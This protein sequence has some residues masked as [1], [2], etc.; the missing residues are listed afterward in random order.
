MELLVVIWL[1]TSAWVLFDAYA[2][3]ARRGLLPGLVDM[4]PAGW[5]LACLLLWVIAFPLYLASRARI[6]AAAAASP[7]KIHRR[8]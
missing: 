4:G 1:A 2:I 8:R 3:G 7:A 6:K 5:G